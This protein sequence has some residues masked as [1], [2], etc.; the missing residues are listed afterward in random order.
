MAPTNK[1]HKTSTEWSPKTK[2]RNIVT[3]AGTFKKQAEKGTTVARLGFF[4]TYTHIHTHAHTRFKTTEHI[5][6]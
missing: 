5:I 6:H 2:T 3:C 1:E 4:L